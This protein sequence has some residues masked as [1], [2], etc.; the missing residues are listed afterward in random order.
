MKSIV[1]RPME[2]GDQEMVMK[3]RTL[4]EVTRYMKTDS[5][6]DLTQQK[7]WFLKQKQK[8]NCYYWIIEVEGK[9]IGVTSI[10]EID[11]EKGTCTRGTYIAEKIDHS[12]EIIT[13]IYANQHDFVFEQLGLNR[14]VIHIFCDNRFVVKLNKMCGFCEKRIL[15]QRICKKGKKYDI[16]ELEL[17]RDEWREKKSKWHYDYIDIITGSDEMD[18]LEEIIK[19][20]YPGYDKTVNMKLFSDGLLDSVVFVAIISDIE[21]VFGVEIPI[22][23][24][25]PENFDTIE[26]MSEVVERL[27]G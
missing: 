11:K 18:K 2:L 13:T 8:N 12:F 5:T 4:P 26:N 7:Q 27:R 21:E 9:A 19:K 3:W 23:L 6:G 15:K 25:N 16:V 1:L 14:I 20:W 22:E 10:T 24:V 17:T